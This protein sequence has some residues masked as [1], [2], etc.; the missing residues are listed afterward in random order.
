M[1]FPESLLE[2]LTHFN[3]ERFWHAHESWESLWLEA[4][5]DVRQ[6]LQGLIQLAAAYHHVQRGTTRG[7]GRLFDAALRRLEAFPNPHLGLDRS[8]AVAAAQRDRQRLARGENA[9]PFP[10]LE[11]AGEVP[12]LDSW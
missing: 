11:L 9:G 6:Y 12:R 1:S 2:G 8:A 7:A 3:A 4:V 10:R 5:T